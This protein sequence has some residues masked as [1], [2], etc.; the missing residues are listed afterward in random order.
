MSQRGPTDEL[1]P[2]PRVEEVSDGIYTYLQP[3]G[4]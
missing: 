4:Q 2:L 3:A 1:A